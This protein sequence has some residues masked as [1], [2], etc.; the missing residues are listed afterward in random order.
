MNITYSLSLYAAIQKHLGRPLAFPSDIASWETEKHQSFNEL[1][2]YHAE[3]ALL[4]PEAG[5]EFLNV[6]NGD[7]FCWGKFWSHLA[8]WYG[9]DFTTPNP[10]LTAYGSVEMP[11]DAPRGFGPRGKVYTTFTFLD[12]SKKAEVVRAWEELK[13]K[14]GLVQSPFNKAAET[15]GLLDN[16]ILGGWPRSLSMNK[17][18][19]LGWHGFVDTKKAI[20]YVIRG[21]AELKMVPPLEFGFGVDVEEA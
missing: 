11:F 13:M 9:I 2:A 7:V 16:E 15:F 20:R 14:H 1:I 18:R 19:N 10:D 21:L 17:S 4:T 8:N 6:G 5:N 12:W 3:W